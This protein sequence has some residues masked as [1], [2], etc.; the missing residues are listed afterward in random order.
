[1]RGGSSTLAPIYEP[2]QAA[3]E[4]AFGA[5]QPPTRM[6]QPP[7]SSL[8]MEQSSLRTSSGGGG[9]GSVLTPV[10]GPHR[11]A[12]AAT[13]AAA[14]FGSD[15]SRGRTFPELPPIATGSCRLSAVSKSMVIVLV[16][17]CKIA[18]II[19][20]RRE[21][22][23]LVLSSCDSSSAFCTIPRP[24]LKPH[25]WSVSKTCKLVRATSPHALLALRCVPV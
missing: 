24:Y 9:G 19:R 22:N 23:W 6:D 17:S 1:M 11:A 15:Q 25:P 8:R 5:D 3:S 12:L 21:D 13:A 16:L 2:H 18:M 4:A 7:L 10:S 20:T 14:A